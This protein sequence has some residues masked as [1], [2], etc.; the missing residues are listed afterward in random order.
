[1]KKFMDE[2]KEFALK[3]NVMDMAVGVIIA[4]AFGN[5]ITAFIENI[6]NPI[7]GLA[8][9]ADLSEV[10]VTIG[11][12]TLGIGAF[13][14][15]ILNFLIMALILF[16]FVKAVNR[17]KEAM[18]KEKAEEAPAEKSDELKALEEIRDLLKT[19]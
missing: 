10:G 2:F 11:S 4:T 8:F 1:M 18:E 15:A 19:R 3:G 12:V 5:I 6:V 14:S 13:I 17:A 9:D 7:I 16:M